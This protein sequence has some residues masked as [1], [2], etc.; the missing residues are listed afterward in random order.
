MEVKS[1]I[2]IA[3]RRGIFDYFEGAGYT[4]TIL[5]KSLSWSNAIFHRRREIQYQLY[6]CGLGGLPVA[7]LVAIFTGMVVTFQTGLYL[8]KLEQESSVGIIVAIAMCR[9]MGPVTT[10]NILAG[11][12]GSKIAAEIGTMNVGDEIEALKV[13]AINPIGYLI[14]PRVLAMCIICPLLTAYADLFG[15]ISGALVS[16]SQLGV[17]FQLYFGNAKQ[18]LEFKDFYSGLIKAGVFGVVIASVACAQGLKAERGAEG[19]GIATMKTVVI[20][21]IAILVFDYIIGWALAVVLGV[22]Q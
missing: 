21:S 20:S 22:G 6:V 1:G 17:D 12:L 18:H 15:I 3:I 14:M 16:N 7:L 19:V 10:C 8:Q 9:E 2:G 4:I 11:L 5:L 13:M